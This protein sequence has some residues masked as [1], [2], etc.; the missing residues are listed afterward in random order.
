MEKK[1][2]QDQ[3]VRDWELNIFTVEPQG[4]LKRSR[5]IQLFDKDFGLIRFP[6]FHHIISLQSRPRTECRMQM[7][8]II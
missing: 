4:Y 3:K 8:A 7:W 6:P 1:E 2:I 5:H